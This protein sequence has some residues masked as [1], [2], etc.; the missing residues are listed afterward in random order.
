MAGTWPVVLI[1]SN[2]E[3]IGHALRFVLQMEKVCAQLCPDATALR[4]SPGLLQAHCLVLLY[5]PPVVDGCELSC[6]A[7]R[8]GALA[9][10]IL[11]VDAA[12]PRV[13]AQAA[14]TGI[15]RYWRSR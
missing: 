3:P 4:D 9:P 6:V 11:L 5:H 1:H 12:T 2:D 8:K 7:R 10:A 14:A 13:K 15:W